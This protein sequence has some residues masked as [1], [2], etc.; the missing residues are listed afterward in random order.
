MSLLKYNYLCSYIQCD[1]V[2]RDYLDMILGALIEK[3]K[4]YVKN[5]PGK[6]DMLANSYELKAIAFS[7]GYVK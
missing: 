7:S 2:Y 4:V 1:P 6:E 5:N 3:V